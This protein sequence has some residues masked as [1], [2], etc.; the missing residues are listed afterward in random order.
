MEQQIIRPEQNTQT[1]VPPPAPEPVPSPVPPAPAP[2]PFPP[3]DNNFIPPPVYDG[4]LASAVNGSSG[5]LSLLLSSLAV[6]IFIL[7]IFVTGLVD[8]LAK[9]Y[10]WF[11]II[12][13]LGVAGLVF[14]LRSEKG[15]DKMDLL[16]LVGII[17]SIIVCINCLIIG[18]Y[19]I[20]LQIELNKFKSQT[21]SQINNNLD[22]SSYDL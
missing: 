2:N 15:K 1:T 7:L 3:K 10:A 14:G 17:L 4:G 19:Y 18:S 6:G 21:N 22:T 5:K 16:G 12:L 11:F 9:A 20:K 13:A 8:S